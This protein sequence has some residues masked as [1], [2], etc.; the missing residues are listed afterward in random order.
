MLTGPRRPAGERH[1]ALGGAGIGGHR[2]LGPQETAAGLGGEGLVGEAEQLLGQGGVDGHGRPVARPRSH[3]CTT[4]SRIVKP[5]RAA[6]GISPSGVVW[7]RAKAPSSTA[8]SRPRRPGGRRRRVVAHQVVGRQLAGPH[9]YLRRHVAQQRPAQGQRVH[10]VVEDVVHVPVGARG[11]QPVL[12]RRG[13]GDD[14]LGGGAG[15]L[16]RG[17]V[18]AVLK[19]ELTLK[20]RRS[21]RRRPGPAGLDHLGRQAGIAGGH[22]LDVLGAG[23]GADAPGRRPAP[24]SP[25]RRRPRRHRPGGHRPPCPGP[26]PRRRP[27]RGR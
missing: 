4:M 6:P 19:D 2:H 17:E 1:Q 25:A 8:A 5:A 26:R 14:G 11:G 15:P 10:E 22:Y 16:E 9:G 18:H 27:G 21:I 7:L 23:A 13:A 20:C 3:P 24:S 12:V